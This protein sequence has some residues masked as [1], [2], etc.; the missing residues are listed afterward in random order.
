MSNRKSVLKGALLGAAVAGVGVAAQSADAGLIYDLRINGQ[1]ITA[2]TYTLTSPTEVVQ[3]DLYVTVTEV[4][5]NGQFSDDALKAITVEWE[6]TGP[7]KGNMSHLSFGPTVNPIN[8]TGVLN[9]TD[10]DGDIDIGIT[11]SPANSNVSH[12]VYTSLN[13]GGV[14]ATDAARLY[15]VGSVNFTVTSA[16][17]GSFATI[18]ARLPDATGVGAGRNTSTQW[19]ENNVSRS[20]GVSG[21][22]A[23]L[24]TFDAVT[25]YA[26]APT[27]VSSILLA[28]TDPGKAN[29]ATGGQVTVVGSQGGYQSE[30]DP[31]TSNENEGQVAIVDI[32]DDAG[33]GPVWVMLDLVG[34]GAEIDDLLADLDADGGT[35]YDIVPATDPFY[36]YLSGLYGGFFNALVRFSDA[37]GGLDANYFAWDFAAHT[38]VVVNAIAVVPEPATLGVLALGAVGLLGR[39]RRA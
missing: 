10:L 26:P 13:P 6:S 1:P 35:V 25:I 28:D 24:M 37:G 36:I 2:N 23:S 3:L 15:L 21:Q 8:N 29:L 19:V 12:W 31:L 17:P 5:P 33:S 27:A 14:F 18:P 11:P 20:L 16:A 22:N 30:I 38:N 7:L 34:P 9:D 39:R 4:A 32:I